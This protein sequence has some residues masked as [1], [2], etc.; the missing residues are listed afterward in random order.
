MTRYRIVER[1]C[2]GCFIIERYTKYWFWPNKWVLYKD[3]LFCH[4][5]EKFVWYSFGSYELAEQYLYDLLNKKFFI[6][7]HNIYEYERPFNGYVY[8]A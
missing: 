3:R 2:D 8:P 6:K 1:V 4:E 5:G 7:S